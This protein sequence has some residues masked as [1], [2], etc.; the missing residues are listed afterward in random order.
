MSQIVEYDLN[1]VFQIQRAV[2]AVLI[3]NRG[4]LHRYYDVRDGLISRSIEDST[5]EPIDRENHATCTAFC[6][7]YL[8]QSGLMPSQGGPDG[9]SPLSL[10]ESINSTT[11]LG[12]AIAIGHEKSS[13]TATAQLPNQYNSPIQ[14]AGYL[15]AI[16]HLKI[17][18]SE[19]AIAVCSTIVEYLVGLIKDRR[20]YVPRIEPSTE[21]SSPY[22]TFWTGAALY[23]WQLFTGGV[24]HV[25]EALS[26]L[27][28]RSSLELSNSITY[29]HAGLASRF[30]VIELI[31]SALTVLRFNTAPEA[32][33]A[34]SYGILL[35]FQEYFKDGSF[36]PSA[37]VF[38]DKEN[39]SLL[40]PTVESLSLLLLHTEPELFLD[41]WTYLYEAFKT[42]HKTE[43]GWYSEYD[44]RY[45]R[46][47]AFMTVSV[48]V[49]LSSFVRLVDEVLDR[50]AAKELGVPPYSPSDFLRKI[51]YPET[52]GQIIKAHVI[53]PIKRNNSELASYSMILYGPPGTSKTT[54]AKKLAQDLL[55]PLLIV[56]QSDFLNRGLDNID[57]EADRIFRLAYYLKNVVLLFDEVEELVVDRAGTNTDKLSRLL[58]TSM[59]PRIHSLRDR[60]RVVFI[61]ATNH[62][63]TI[64]N[65]ASRLGRFDIIH[66]VMPPSSAERA[67]ML[68]SLLEDF[69]ADDTIKKTIKDEVVI[70][71]TESF[72]YM[73][74]KALVRR[75][76][77][78]IR[79]EKK[80]LSMSLVIEAIEVGKRSIN[81][82]ALSE[83]RR[84]QQ[85]RDR[86]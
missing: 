68:D 20:G 27:A 73:D 75:I 50:S 62:V 52:L 44:V 38:A 21:T 45:G 42:L 23:E 55:W 77:T 61:F 80:A 3:E 47:T 85:E 41:K 26:E 84:I 24:Q 16:R 65:A 49:F 76:I 15:A 48:M 72:G 29:H 53:E 63:E 28:M 60:S 82:E 74:L 56:N 4:L 46:P 17:D 30:D 35:I 67:A 58:T 66:C 18:K 40:V 11:S 71:Q 2:E 86:P 19:E 70:S 5:I 6:L 78:N 34:A 54:I 22:L 33:R 64:D 13:G 10:Q 32:R 14:L 57:A 31:Y 9:G 37:P 7:Y 51:S 83:F 25:E 59:L 69:A 8:A 36:S 39:F 81:T 1:T 12:R 79:I 43:D